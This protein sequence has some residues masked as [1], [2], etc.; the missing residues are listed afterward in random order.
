MYKDVLVHSWGKSKKVQIEITRT[1]QVILLRLF[2]IFLI[3][4]LDF[5]S[6]P[7]KLPNSGAFCSTIAHLKFD[8]DMNQI[9]I[10]PNHVSE[11]VWYLRDIVGNNPLRL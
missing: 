2:L 1:V 7:S 9:L 3:E 6:F 5:L 4:V 11:S 10:I 8:N